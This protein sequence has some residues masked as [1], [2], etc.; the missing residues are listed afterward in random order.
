MLGK[1]PQTEKKIQVWLLGASYFA[2]E[3]MKYNEIEI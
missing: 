2:V 3:Q 1:S